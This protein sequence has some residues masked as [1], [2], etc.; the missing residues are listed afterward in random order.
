M[1]RYTVNVLCGL[2]F[3]ST[4]SV[5]LCAAD[6]FGNPTTIGTPGQFEIQIGGGKIKKLDLDGKKSTATMQIGTVTGSQSMPAFSGEL[7]ENQAFIGVSYALNPRSQLFANLGNGKDSGQQSGSRAI[8]IKIST[9]EETSK[10]RMGLML[11]AQQVTIDID[12]PFSLNSPFI[13]SDG[14]NNYY[15]NTSVLN[16]TEQ[17]KY[18]RMEAFFGVSENTGIFRPYGGLCLTRITGTDTISLDDTVSVNSTPVGGGAVTTT[19][20][21][22]MYNNKSDL[23]GSGYLSGVL[24]LSINPD[25]DLGMTVE[26]QTGIQQAIMLSGNIRF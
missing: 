21:R 6:M 10:I 24:G 4:Y 20:Q 13:V 14:I 11:R 2:V 17:L 9:P 3:M 23:S 15:L 12:G 26:I 18:T 5:A 16:G 22:V 19:T 7:S 25:S 8:G 1:K